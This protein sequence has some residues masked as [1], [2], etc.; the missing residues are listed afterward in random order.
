MATGFVDPYR[1]CEP[2]AKPTPSSATQA[3]QRAA[4]AARA[5][6]NRPQAGQQGVP[7]NRAERRQAA[8]VAGR[9]P[10]ESSV[11]TAAQQAASQQTI[12]GRDLVKAA[13]AAL[14]QSASL[15]A[16][17]VYRGFSSGALLPWREMLPAM[18]FMA[19]VMLFTSLW[20]GLGAGRTGA[21]SGLAPYATGIT[22]GLKV[23]FGLCL[24]SIS[25]RSVLPA[26]GAFGL[27]GYLA[28]TGSG[29]Q[30]FGVML[31]GFGLVLVWLLGPQVGDIAD[32]NKRK[33]VK[34]A[35]AD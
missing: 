9:R 17:Q 25:W 35:R 8:R 21:L 18:W 3:Q 29:P 1:T 23:A 13:P 31:A 4:Q 15:A 6:L 33:T 34:A 16:L 12:T 11:N 14:G 26:V 2:M 30:F 10:K 27:S 32:Q 24:V 20:F 7:Q 28:A 19:I 5:F 22:M